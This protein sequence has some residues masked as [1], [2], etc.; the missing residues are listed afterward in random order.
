MGSVA[1][2][3]ISDHQLSKDSCKS[4]PKTSCFPQHRIYGEKTNVCSIALSCSWV[5]ICNSKSCRLPEGAVGSSKAL[6]DAL[7]AQPQPRGINAPFIPSRWG[8]SFSPGF[9]VHLRNGVP[10][11]GCFW[12]PEQTAHRPQRPPLQEKHAACYKVSANLSIPPLE[13]SP[14]TLNPGSEVNLKADIVC[15]PKI[16][17]ALGGERCAR[18]TLSVG[19]LLL[20]VCH[21]AVGQCYPYGRCMGPIPGYHVS[22]PSHSQSKNHHEMATTKKWVAS[23]LWSVCPSYC[24]C[25]PVCL[26]PNCNV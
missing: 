8:R 26:P 13:K 23:T 4:V 3:S 12:I 9:W 10:S 21:S 17:A 24:S 25:T 16:I 1:C 22:F 7:A 15:S 11:Q 14:I 2:M 19:Y 20:S 6:H 18:I 5:S